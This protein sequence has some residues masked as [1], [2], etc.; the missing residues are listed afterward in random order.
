MLID[1]LVK[2]DDDTR[3]AVRWD[4][5]FD[6]FHAAHERRDIHRLVSEHDHPGVLVLIRNGE[7]VGVI[8]HDSCT[9]ASGLR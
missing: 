9:G 2:P 4:K 8:R 3:A 6:S 7:E 5:P 1:P